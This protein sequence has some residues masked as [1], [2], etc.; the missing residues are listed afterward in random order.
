MLVRA[1]KEGYYEHR[2]RKIGDVFELKPVKGFIGEV[3]NL[4]PK[5]WTAEEQFTDF[6]MEK[7]DDDGEKPKAKV[8][9]KKAKPSEDVI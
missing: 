1:T 7:V 4:K 9:A 3:P 8:A 5:S 2:Y 6:W